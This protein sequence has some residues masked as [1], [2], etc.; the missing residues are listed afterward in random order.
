[1]LS[2]NAFSA[3]RR[4]G[5]TGDLRL[6]N[7][8]NVTRALADDTLQGRAA[9]DAIE[10]VLAGGV[11]Q[12]AEVGADGVSV[13]LRALP[14]FVQGRSRGALVLI[15]DVTDVRHRDRQLMSKDATIREINHRVKNNLQTVAALLRMQARRVET[16]EA[17]TALADSVRRISAI[18]EVHEMLALSVD[19]SL[20]GDD[21]V[22][23]LTRMMTE[24]SS[25]DRT[26]AFRRTGELGELGADIATPLAMVLTE[27]LQNAVEHAFAPGR[28]GTV[29]GDAARTSNYLR[30]TVSDDGI[31]L[32]PGF[33][34]AGSDRLGLRIVDVLVNSELR[35]TVAMT[36]ADSGGTRA[37]IELPLDGKDG[38]PG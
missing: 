3:Y 19:D 9:A 10:S 13:R 37:T 26:V 7:L 22:N 21:V 23:R 4:L 15:R 8:S 18:A 27:L 6:A 17:R 11:P 14:L 38:P 2:P 12:R 36:T 1:Y 30:V 5:A 28:G 32:P 24:V 33:T 34:V 16:P 29:T 35:G 31:G 25:A 20:D